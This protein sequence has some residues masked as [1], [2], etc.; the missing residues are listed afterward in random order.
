MAQVLIRGLDDDLLA[1][2]REAAKAN[3][4]TLEA[5]LREALRQVRPMRPKPP[6]T[7]AAREALLK[8]FAELRG[9]TSGVMQTP[10][11]VLIREDRDHGH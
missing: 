6:M 2:Y 8:E 3:G 4:R 11:E 7:P 10:S 5:E 1:D 9:M